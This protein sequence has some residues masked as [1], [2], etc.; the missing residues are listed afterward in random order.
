MSVPSTRLNRALGLIA[1]GTAVRD[2]LDR[3]VHGRTGAL[4]TLGN[5][6]RLQA[7]STGGFAIDV[8]FSATALRELAKMDGAI[9]LNDALDR[10]LFAGVHLMPDAAV[11]TTETGTR[12]RTADRVARQIGVPTVTVSASMSTI[13]LFVD[14]TRWTVQRPEQLLA[15]ANQALATLS[16][17]QERLAEA[18][19]RLS[20]AEVQDTA[21]VR[22]VAVIA[23]RL[24]MVRRLQNEVNGYT[25]ELGTD[26]RLVRLQLQE[27]VAG[28][29]EL[30]TGLERDY[31]G[32]KVGLRLARL[33]ELD[34]DDLAHPAL[35]AQA[36]GL[37]D[38]V[39]RRLSPLG[40]RQLA[41]IGR[42]PASVADALVNHF[43]SLQGL[44]GASTA[45]LLGV[46]G[47]DYRIARTVREGLIRLA[48]SAYSERLN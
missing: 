13:S 35:I 32:E 43:G 9:I 40:H 30:A 47:V 6:A 37:G 34:T 24:E 46:D 8:P 28:L 39:G 42:L 25:I 36:C 38:D 4:V 20:A 41:Q 29:D 5:N 1:P 17:Y 22:D 21:T 3:I 23:Q 18:T 45:D 26:G 7:L 14:D 11:E 2:G 19:A 12:H 10:I 16:R 27:L 44:F 15:R 48:E 33:A 31:C